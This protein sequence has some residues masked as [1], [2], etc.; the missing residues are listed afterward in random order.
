MELLTAVICDS[1]SDYNGKLCILGAF[2]TLGSSKFPIK[3]PHCTLAL[4]FIFQAEDH[5]PHQFEIR[6]VNADGQ[7]LLPRGP[8]RFNVNVDPIPMDRYFV[9]RNLILNMQGLEIPAAGEYAFDLIKDGSALKRI[10]LQVIQ[11]PN[12]PSNPNK[13]PPFPEEPS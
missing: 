1:A 2:D 4:R 8:L 3:H 11:G 13:L 6:F 12:M 5:G 10:P 7:E 9:S